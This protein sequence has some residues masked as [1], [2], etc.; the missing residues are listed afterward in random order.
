MKLN[1]KLPTVLGAFAVALMGSAPAYSQDLDLPDISQE[2]VA[3]VDVMDAGDELAPEPFEIAFAGGEGPPPVFN[4]ALPMAPDGP[5]AFLAAFHGRRGGMGGGM[6]PGGGCAIL[7]GLDLSDGQ[8]E[9][10][11]ALK[12]SFL[13]KAG[14]KMLALSTAKR[15][16]C[17]A[18]LAPTVDAKQVKELQTSINGLKADLS[19]LKLDHKLAAMDV[20]TAEQRKQIRDRMIKGSACGP[21]ACGGGRGFMGKMMM[22][23]MGPP[24]R[25][26]GCPV[27]PGGSGGPPPGPPPGPEG[28]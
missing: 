21:A 27:G 28:G 20:L 15:H 2:P 19:N 23:R 8:F 24:G 11:F 16:L 22:K 14:P 10:L 26:P 1:R 9:K 5:P 7:R 6:G 25:G 12:N 17:N 13:D 3:T 18:M 4:V